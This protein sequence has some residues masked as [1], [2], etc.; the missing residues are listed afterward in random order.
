MGLFI[1]LFSDYCEGGAVTAALP[2]PDTV[3][4]I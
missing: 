2:E 1:S 4:F 3:A